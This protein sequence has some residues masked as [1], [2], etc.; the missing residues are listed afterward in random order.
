MSKNESRRRRA[1]GLA[2][3]ALAAALVGVA[4]LFGP[5]G[6]GAEVEVAPSAGPEAA[7]GG[8]IRGRALDG[9]SMA[10][11]EGARVI[12]E[13]EG[14]RVEAAAAA[15]GGFEL[16]TAGE[17]LEWAIRVEA[18]GY[19]SAPGER[20][21][22]VEAGEVLEGVQ[23]K[24]WRMGRAVGRVE[25]RGEPVAGARL[26][27]LAVGRGAP[28]ALDVETGADGGFDVLLW[29]GRARLV[30]EAPGFAR[31]E[32]R[33]IRV[34]GGGLEAGVVI[35]MTERGALRV[36][37]MLEGGEAVE[38]AFVAPQ[39]VDLW[40]PEPPRTDAEGQVLLD[41]VPVGE[42]SVR[43]WAPRFTEV[44]G[45]PAVIKAGVET[46]LEVRL[47]PLEGISGQV[48]DREGAPVRGAQVTLSP[49]GVGTSVDAQQSGEAG[50]FGFPTLESGRYS[51]KATHPRHSA[52]EEVVVE[53]GDREPVRL[54]LGAGGAI[55]GEVRDPEG[56]AVQSFSVVV[57][58]FE[59]LEAALVGEARGPGSCSP[60]RFEDAGGR[61]VLGDLAPGR[62]DLHVDAAG[63]GPG[64]VSGIEVQAGRERGGVRVSLTRGAVLAGRVVD[65]GGGRALEG[66]Q[67]SVF[68]SARRGRRLEPLSA[69]TDEAGEFVIEGLGP[70]RRSLRARK[71]GFTTRDVDGIEVSDRGQEV[72]EVAMTALAEGDVPKVEYSGIGATLEVAPDGAL[73]ILKLMEGAAGERFGLKRGDEI[74][75]IDGRPVK[76]LG[77]ARA[78]ELIRGEQ[79]VEVEL[80]IRRAGEPYPF[81]VGLERG[82]V[83]YD[84]P[85]GRRR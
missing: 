40:R 47:A 28:E 59:P 42:V 5:W 72:L 58:R 29:P 77:L 8:V 11:I 23:V 33:E 35:D 44:L 39:G 73:K 18:P 70:G 32:S 76:D 79:G 25:H 67:I 16:R 74:L 17:G 60:A 43:V 34:V 15:D 12:I 48:V 51:L 9:E 22:R 19:R 78:V 69:V 30:A 46:L 10:A 3:L 65:A 64:E 37:V 63:F 66:V 82:Q 80:E 45:G 62:Y 53:A 52:S 20:L 6:E 31:A 57:E 49:V 21:V 54:V 41:Q 68:D 85:H 83:I 81:V 27:V 7:L 84:A 38:G 13:R 4:W 56:R 26:S 50:L 55:A 36:K 71:R 2:G 61:V 24:A 75:A 1:W 14:H